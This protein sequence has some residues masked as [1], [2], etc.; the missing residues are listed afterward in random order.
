MYTMSTSTDSRIVTS[1]S[2]KK[3]RFGVPFKVLSD[4]A[5]LHPGC[6]VRSVQLPLSILLKGYLCIDNI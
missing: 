5:G 2:D 4:H 6:K 3:Y 1:T